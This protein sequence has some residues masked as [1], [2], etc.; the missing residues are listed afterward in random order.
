MKSSL[1]NTSFSLQH[2]NDSLRGTDADTGRG[3]YGTFIP[4]T[5][6]EEKV[7]LKG[8]YIMKRYFSFLAVLAVFVIAKLY[9][10]M[11]VFSGLA[12]L[13]TALGAPDPR[14]PVGSCPT[15][16]NAVVAAVF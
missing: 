15:C 3:G 14:L 10:P 13:V 4:D 9:L 8:N 5:F 11:L 7:T 2:H 1:S 16:A 12:V 6:A